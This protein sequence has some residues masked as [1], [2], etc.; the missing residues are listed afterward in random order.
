MPPGTVLPDDF[1]AVPH[2][3]SM[4]MVPKLF[5]KEIKIID[6]SA[7]YRIKEINVYEKYYKKHKS[8]ELVKKA[9]SIS[10][11]IDPIIPGV[12]T[13]NEIDPIFVNGPHHAL[14]LR[15]ILYL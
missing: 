2:G 10:A 1:L 15:R 9:K 12:C 14:E 6:L 13:D 4:D 8:P 3:E 5:E 11:R 7:D